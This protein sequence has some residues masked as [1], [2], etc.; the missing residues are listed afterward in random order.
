MRRCFSRLKSSGSS[1]PATWRYTESFSRI[2]P[3]TKRSASGFAGSPFS[4]ARSGEAIILPFPGEE[5]ANEE[6]TS[7]PRI[8]LLCRRRCG[9]R[10]VRDRGRGQNAVQLGERPVHISLAAVFKIGLVNR[11]VAVAVV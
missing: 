11:S 10:E 2:E 7:L 4:N 9:N 1:V 8:L 5:N 6:S 3:S